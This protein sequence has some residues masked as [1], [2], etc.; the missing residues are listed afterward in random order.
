MHLCIHCSNDFL[1]YN[2]DD[3]DYNRYLLINYHN[4]FQWRKEK[5]I[6]Y[7][8]YDQFNYTYHYNIIKPFRGWQY[9]LRTRKPTNLYV[10]IFKGSRKLVQTCGSN[11]NCVIFFI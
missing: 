1:K 2:C 4:H 10:V 7:Y 3:D 8:I 5:T 9:T 6:E 11:G